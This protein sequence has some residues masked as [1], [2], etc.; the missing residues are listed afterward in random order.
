VSRSS[1]VASL[2]AR[3]QVGSVVGIPVAS[4]G[5]PEEGVSQVWAVTVN[6]PPFWAKAG[7]YT[8]TYL[9]LHFTHR[10]AHC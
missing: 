10:T 6:R 1:S 5:V 9:E 7:G 3:K 4:E 2:N 8:R